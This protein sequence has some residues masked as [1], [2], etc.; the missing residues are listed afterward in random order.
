MASTLL[1]FAIGVGMMGG[2]AAD[3]LFTGH[4]GVT[5]IDAPLRPL[6]TGNGDA[7][8]TLVGRHL[9]VSGHFAGL[10]GP[11]TKIR[12]HA[13]S[14]TGVRGTPFGDL[15]GTTG[16]NGIVSGSLDLTEEQVAA[17]RAGHVY[18]QLDSLIAPAGNLW[19][20]L[21]PAEASR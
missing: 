11:A 17:L 21:V 18:L 12:L 10:Q 4:L 15:E 5:P 8:G 1:I 2:A 19:G 3:E 13:G 14:T 6:V 20:W 9:T 16:T 7:W